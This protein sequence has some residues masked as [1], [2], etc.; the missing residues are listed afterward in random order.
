[1]A[2]HQNEQPGLLL[3]PDARAYADSFGLTAEHFRKCNQGELID[4]DEIPWPCKNGMFTFRGEPAK[5]Y[6]EHRLSGEAGKLLVESRRRGFVR[7]RIPELSECIDDRLFPKSFS[8]PCVLPGDYSLLFLMVC[9]GPPIITIGTRTRHF[10]VTY[11]PTRQL[12]AWGVLPKYVPTAGRLSLY[13]RRAVACDFL[14]N[15]IEDAQPTPAIADAE[16]RIPQYVTLDQ[17][18]GIVKRSKRTLEKKLTR[19][20]NPLPPPDIEGGGGKANEWDW[21]KLRPFLEQEYGKKLPEKFP[22]Y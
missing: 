1:M 10:T 14:S 4:F 17:A 20:N 8:F 15:L 9:G 18:A 11:R 16:D 7:D 12:E 5:L 21:A 2:T 3:S 22:G 13:E 19:R 6:L